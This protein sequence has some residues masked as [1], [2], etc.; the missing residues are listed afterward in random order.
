VTD[1]L[2][3]DQKKVLR[4]LPQPV[5]DIA[6]SEHGIMEVTDREGFRYQVNPDGYVGCSWTAAD[7]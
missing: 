1:A 3:E 4:D 2:T 7:E 6:L 5:S